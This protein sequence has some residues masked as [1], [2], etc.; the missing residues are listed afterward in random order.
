MNKRFKDLSP[1]VFVGK[2]VLAP[3]Y[4]NK[5]FYSK[6]YTIKFLTH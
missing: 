1:T 5:Q 4:V 2:K 3:S 6:F